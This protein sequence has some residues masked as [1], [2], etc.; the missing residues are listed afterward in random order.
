MGVRDSDVTIYHNTLH[1][2]D[3]AGGTPSITIGNL[4]RDTQT[5]VQSPDGALLATIEDNR[6]AGREPWIKVWEPKSRTLLHSL[7][8][9]AASF[10]PNGKQM[11][12]IDKSGRLR[13][14]ETATWKDPRELP[15]AVSYQ[16]LTFAPDGRYLAAIASEHEPDVNVQIFDANT[17][18]VIWQPKDRTKGMRAVAFAP[19]GK[20]LATTNLETSVLV[21][22]LSERKE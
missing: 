13:L 17:G 10:S 6:G 16:S 7:P 11:A 21:W 19:D 3:I 8:G 2:R 18:K 14:F 12:A 4:H 5:I 20:S 9:Y 15:K 1:I 22:D